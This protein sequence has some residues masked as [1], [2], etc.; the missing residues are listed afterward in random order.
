MCRLEAQA[1][2]RSSGRSW[3]A[4]FSP[5]SV[6]SYGLDAGNLRESLD[7]VGIP[8]TEASVAVG[9]DGYNQ[10]ALRFSDDSSLALPVDPL[11]TDAWSNGSLHEFTVSIWVKPHSAS[12]GGILGR[13]LAHLPDVEISPSISMTSDGSVVWTMYDELGQNYSQQYYTPQDRPYVPVLPSSASTSLTQVLEVDE[14]THLA[15]VKQADTVMFYRNGQRWGFSTLAPDSQSNVYGQIYLNFLQDL[16]LH[17][18]IDDVRFYDVGLADF[19]V[20]HLFGNADVDTLRSKSQRCFAGAPCE[21]AGL[22][23]EGLS[24]LNKYAVLTHCGRSPAVSGMPND[25]ISDFG[26][27]QKVYWGFATEEPLT[28][29]GG[30]YKIC[31]CGGGS[32]CAVPED[33]K[34]L[35]GTLVVV[36][37][38]LGQERTCTLGQVAAFDITGVELDAGDQ[39]QIL[40]TC[41]FNLTTPGVPQGAVSDLQPSSCY[42]HVGLGVVDALA[43]HGSGLTGKTQSE[44]C[45]LCQRSLYSDCVIWVYRP[46]DM[47]CFLYR[48]VARVE[49]QEDRVL[50]VVNEWA[51]VPNQLLMATVL[52]GPRNGANSTGP[53]RLYVCRSNQECLFTTALELTDLDV[54]YQTFQTAVLW[55]TGWDWSG[56]KIFSDSEDRWFLESLVVSALGVSGNFTYS[57]W[58]E[59]VCGGLPHKSRTVAIH[60]WRSMGCRDS[61]HGLRRA[62]SSVLVFRNWCLQF[63]CC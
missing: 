55:P 20:E 44:C 30:Y 40:D 49:R 43:A 57:G 45:A 39:L 61:F 9:R 52:T 38:Y 10:G 15:F 17:A 19:A 35:V 54:G 21:L 41:G 18:S 3:C 8:V 59:L 50:G 32:A 16:P 26:T 60:I 34:V 12:E 28:A 2:Q 13:R 25:G 37:P 56:I 23:G 31:W 47:T 46:S 62:V 42:G 22:V 36:G 63:V 1:E 6:A 51:T 48:S 27:T 4:I 53:F 11:G 5:Q 7:S 29:G 58:L 24:D 14:W 33:F